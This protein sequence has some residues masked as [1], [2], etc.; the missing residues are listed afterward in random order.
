MVND[1][2][3]VGDIFLDVTLQNAENPLKMRLGGIVHCARALWALDENY[4]V[5]YFAPK[6]L[7]PHIEKYLVKFGGPTLIHLGEVT[8]CPYVMLI[9][10]AKEIGKQGYEFLFREDVQLEYNEKN[11][12]SLNEKNN[13]ILISG[14]YDIRKVIQNLNPNSRVSIDLANNLEH[15]QLLKQQNFIFENVFI[16]TSSEYF[17][18]FYDEQPFTIESFLGE[19]KTIA[20]KAVLKEN[21]GG[22]RAI[23]FSKNNIIKVPSQTQPICHSVGVGDVYDTVYLLKSKDLGFEESLNFASWVATEYALTTFPEDF[24]HSV[25]MVSKIPIGDLIALKGVQLQWEDRKKINIYIAAPDFEY[26]DT[27]LIDTLSNCLVYHNFSPRRPIKENG[28]MKENATIPEKQNLYNLDMQLLSECKIMVAV[29]LFNDPGTLVEIGIA[30][31]RKI[32]VFIYDPYSI[33]KNCMLTQT[34]DK[35][36]SNLDEI[37]S[38]VFLS[39]SKLTQ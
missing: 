31:E 17:L 10:E 11:L 34:P 9:A 29:L 8:T 16:S 30:A 4:S 25:E 20:R 3:L 38:E 7:V 19:F 15:F 24:K 2:C 12:K 13:L 21:R 23:D 26:V 22:S 32:P 36:S 27:R 5:A 39:A 33:A 28:Q 6:Y 35:I 14:N 37:I 18:K 1:I